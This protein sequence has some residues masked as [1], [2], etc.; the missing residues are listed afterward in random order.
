[1]IRS[2]F[3]RAKAMA[4]IPSTLTH[5]GY[6]TCEANI[7]VNDRLRNAC[8]VTTTLA[9]AATVTLLWPNESN[10]LRGGAPSVRAAEAAVPACTDKDI[11]D[12]LL[13]NMFTLLKQQALKAIPDD[14]IVKKWSA[15]IENIRQLSDGG[16]TRVCKADLIYD[17]LPPLSP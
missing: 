15:S 5:A 17:S 12:Q 8:K 13:Y 1:M 6:A 4:K 14:E 9:L 7:R 2:A 10:W 3:K 11:L 16:G